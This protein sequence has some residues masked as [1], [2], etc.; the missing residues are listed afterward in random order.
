MESNYSFCVYTSD[1]KCKVEEIIK[2]EGYSNIAVVDNKEALM[3]IKHI[4]FLFV[5]KDKNKKIPKYIGK[6]KKINPHIKTVCVMEDYNPYLSN[7]IISK[8]CNG[9]VY[10]KDDG[11]WIEELVDYIDDFV[12]IEENTKCIE[13]LMYSTERRKKQILTR[14]KRRVS[15]IFAS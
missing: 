5:C 13:K 1:F 12:M 6:F 11:K 3:N 8:G 4:D 2:D 14:Y 7:E 15:D 10:K 9:I